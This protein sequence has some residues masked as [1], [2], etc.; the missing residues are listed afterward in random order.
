M[1][2]LI[3][4]VISA[5]MLALLLVWWRW[6]AFRVWIEAPKYSMLRQERRFEEHTSEQA[7]PPGPYN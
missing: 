2:N 7:L 3:V 1:I 4:I 6:P 5:V